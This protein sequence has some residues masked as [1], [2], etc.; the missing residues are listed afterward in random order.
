MLHGQRKGLVN[1]SARRQGQRLHC[2]GPSRRHGRISAEAAEAVEAAEAAE[3]A[4]AHDGS[5]VCVWWV[6]NFF[7]GKLSLFLLVMPTTRWQ[8]GP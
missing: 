7:E 5:S 1:G 3:A 8:G 6:I 4:Q 2:H